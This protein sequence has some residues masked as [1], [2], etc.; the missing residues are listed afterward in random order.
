MTCW[1]NTDQRLTSKHKTTAKIKELWSIPSGLKTLLLLQEPQ[2]ARAAN[3]QKQRSRRPADLLSCSRGERRSSDRFHASNSGKKRRKVRGEDG[4][5]LRVQTQV[6]EKL[7]RLIRNVSDSRLLF[8][9]LFFFSKQEIA[10]HSLLSHYKGEGFTCDL[11]AKEALLLGTLENPEWIPALRAKHR[12]CCSIQL[13]FDTLTPQEPPP[14]PRPR[15]H[16]YGPRKASHSGLW[17]DYQRV[18]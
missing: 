4:V 6:E 17:T 5:D 15:L 1:V 7:R 12:A 2:K 8:F 3:I 13:M 11:S 9:H 16:R 14:P 10:C 18:Q